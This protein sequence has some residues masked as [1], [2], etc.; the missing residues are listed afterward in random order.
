MTCI[1]KEWYYTLDCRIVNPTYQKNHLKLVGEWYYIL[2]L[3]LYILYTRNIN[4]CWLVRIA[5]VLLAKA[6]DYFAVFSQVGF[7]FSFEHCV[8]MQF[9]FQH[10]CIQKFQ[11]IFWGRTDLYI[12][13][14]KIV[15]VV[16]DFRNHIINWI[17]SVIVIMR[18]I[19]KPAQTV[20]F[21]WLIT[22]TDVQYTSYSP[23]SG[24]LGCDS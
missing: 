9:F 20:S 18:W 8:Q 21:R 12:F 22:G 24:S 19:I 10:L 1:F 14:K 3:G 13:V 15:T 11:F 6:F 23:N 2:D 4:S 5:L 17:N 7:C 16:N